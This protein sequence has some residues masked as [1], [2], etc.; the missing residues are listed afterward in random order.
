MEL[1]DIL[2][3]M[4]HYGVDDMESLMQVLDAEQADGMCEATDGCLVEP[5]GH[6]P[7]GCPSWPVK[8]NL[9]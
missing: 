2:E 1:P 4:K 9:I 5:D 7:H 3:A 6:C 8:L